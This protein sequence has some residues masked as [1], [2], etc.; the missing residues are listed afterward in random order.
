MAAWKTLPSWYIVSANDRIISPD[1]E[2]AL[3][4]KIGA[5][6]TT[7][8]TSHVPQESRPADV[9]AVIIAAVDAS[10]K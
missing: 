7:L 9:A 5:T 2:R 3:A 4:R 1:L 8:P 10:T 6:T